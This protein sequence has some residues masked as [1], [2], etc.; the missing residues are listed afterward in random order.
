MTRH[1]G[2]EEKK[3]QTMVKTDDDTMFSWNGVSLFNTEGNAL[4]SQHACKT[5]E[6]KS[7]TNND[8]AKLSKVQELQGKSEGQSDIKDKMDIPQDLT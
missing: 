3:N 2:E 4:K 7:L 8:N 1:S 5:T 6:D